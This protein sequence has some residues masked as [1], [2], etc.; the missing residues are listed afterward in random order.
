MCLVRRFWGDSAEQAKKCSTPSDRSVASGKRPTLL[1]E[2][3]AAQPQTDRTDQPGS[4]PSSSP[5]PE[6][7]RCG[8]GRAG[9]R[10]KLYHV[11]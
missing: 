8:E 1:S 5:R 2:L 9:G 7:E 10:E 3:D 4:E 6:W 11:G